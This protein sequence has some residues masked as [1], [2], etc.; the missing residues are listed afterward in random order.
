MYACSAAS[1]GWDDMRVV[2]PT[3]S[4]MDLDSPWGELLDTRLRVMTWNLWWRFGPFEERQPLIAATLARAEPDI[5]CLQE[6]WEEQAASLAEGL[7]YRHVY[8]SRFERS[9]GFQ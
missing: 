8:S 3:F 5:V 9:D 2:Q 4:P 7:G 1:S 6:V